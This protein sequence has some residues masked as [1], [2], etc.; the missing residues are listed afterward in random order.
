MK[1]K[2]PQNKVKRNDYPEKQVGFPERNDASSPE[3]DRETDRVHVDPQTLQVSRKSAREVSEE[4]GVFP[5]ET[6]PEKTGEDE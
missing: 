3:P 1:S 2:D 4:L 6:G 5:R